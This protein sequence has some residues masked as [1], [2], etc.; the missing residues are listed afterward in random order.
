MF[1]LVLF[2]ME[3]RC[4]DVALESFPELPGW[5]RKSYLQ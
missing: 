2:D 3:M 1:W 5:N 4:K